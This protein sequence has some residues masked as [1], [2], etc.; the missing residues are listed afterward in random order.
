[1]I[2]SRTVDGLFIPNLCDLIENMGP[3]TASFVTLFCET[4]YICTQDVNQKVTDSSYKMTVVILFL[5]LVVVRS[6]KGF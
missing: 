4:I 2:L 5:G 1:M 3:C 6:G